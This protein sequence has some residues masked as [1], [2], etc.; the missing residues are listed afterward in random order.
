MSQL[1]INNI[2]EQMIF[3]TKPGV[4]WIRKGEWSQNGNSSKASTCPMSNLFGKTV[5]YEKNIT[6]IENTMWEAE[7]VEGSQVFIR[8]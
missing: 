5:G 3:D 6:L 1:S 2:G 8:T 7:F 4:L